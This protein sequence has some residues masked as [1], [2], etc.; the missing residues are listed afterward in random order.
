M[1][2]GHPPSP[3]KPD[4]EREPL[5]IPDTPHATLR[6]RS[7]ILIF[8]LALVLGFGLMLYL[9]GVIS[10]Y[11]PLG[12]DVY[13]HWVHTRAFWD[14]QSPYSESVERAA[15]Q[16]VYGR[17]RGPTDPPFPFTYPAYLALI[18]LPILFIPPGMV[19]VA[20][21]AAM[22]AVLSTIVVT[23]SLALVPRPRPFVW[24]LAVLS[25]LVFRPALLS[26]INGQYALFVLGCAALT[27][28]L[29][30]RAQDW[31]AGPLVALATIKPSVGLF[32]PV[33]LIVWAIRWRRWK[34]VAS[35]GLAMGIL[36]AATI[37]RIG[38]W[39]PGFIQHTVNYS[40]L[41]H[42]IGLAWSIDWVL[43]WPGIIWASLSLVLLL[44]GARQLWSNRRFPW[45]VLI[46]T[47]NLNLLLT[48]HT[49]EYDLAML[50]IPLLWLGTHS[51]GSVWR[52][53][54][55]MLLVW[56]PWL[57][58]AVFVGFGGTVDDW[59]SLIWS[60]YPSLLICAV[61]FLLFYNPLSR[62]IP[63]SPLPDQSG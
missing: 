59:W 30:D 22:C 5:P 45:P 19:G 2:Q 16:L 11:W 27:Y 9:R 36:M 60:F 44:S 10:G 55:W 57:S 14:G 52:W 43:T 17:A 1:G 56:L 31:M 6:G 41:R 23:W 48:P 32:L 63:S 7:I 49:V 58:W 51:G 24:G 3:R 54:A 33:V 62:V 18:L 47:L 8:A 26:I 46:A 38:W 61:L 12:V 20:W 28:Y 34:L 35:S 42:G 37:A 4:P 15:E 50:L 21:G 39:L 53:A 25:L 29:L 40:S 13:S